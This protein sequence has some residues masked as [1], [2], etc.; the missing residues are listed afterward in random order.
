MPADAANRD[1]QRIHVTQR[2]SF[3]VTDGSRLQVRFVVQCNAI[4]R[5]GK[6]R[7]QAVLEHRPR[8]R[9]FFFRG[10]P[11]HHKSPLPPVLQ[12]AQQLCRANQHA[13]VNVVA[14]GVHHI[15]FVSFVIHCAGLAG[16][17]KPRLFLDRQRVEVRAN[18]HR[19]AAAVA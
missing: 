13:H 15:D 18:K 11:N 9:T 12:R 3:D 10:L 5:P 14:A 2:V 17:R 4:I 8:A 19:G 7:E 1:V 6:A 16:V